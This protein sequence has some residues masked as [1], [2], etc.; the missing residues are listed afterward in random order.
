MICA[1]VISFHAFEPNRRRREGEGAAKKIKNHVSNER[2]C[3]IL[4][5][6]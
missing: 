5:R 3:A 4:E 1:T 2:E 6:K